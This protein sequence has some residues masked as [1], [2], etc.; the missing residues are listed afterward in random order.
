MGTHIG[1]LPYTLCHLDL[2]RGGLRGRAVVQPPGFF[3]FGNY[4]A[5]RNVPGGSTVTRARDF[6]DFHSGRA[7]VPAEQVRTCLAGTFAL[8]AISSPRQ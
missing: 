5:R 1:T 2:Q 7:G 6:R 3:L 4:P 8:R